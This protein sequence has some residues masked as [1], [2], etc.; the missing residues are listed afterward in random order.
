M[1]SHTVQKAVSATG[2]GFVAYADAEVD[3]GH[4]A[5]VKA[6]SVNGLEFRVYDP[7]NTNF[8]G[9]I[10]D[11]EFGEWTDE[12]NG[13]GLGRLT[14]RMSDRVV[15]KYRSLLADDNVIRVHFRNADRYAWRV[16]AGEDV[17][18][19][20]DEKNG[21][22][23]GL[24]GPGA[25]DVLEEAIVFPEYP[26]TGDP[27]REA[28]DRYFGYMSKSG[29]TSLHGSK[30]QY[31]LVT[32]PKVTS[33]SDWTAVEGGT[34]GATSVGSG[35]GLSGYNTLKWTYSSS[36]STGVFLRLD[37]GV[38][39]SVVP[40]SKMSARVS[41]KVSGD[42]PARLIAVFDTGEVADY[43]VTIP[44][45]EFYEMIFDDITVPAGAYFMR[46]GIKLDTN[47]HVLG[48]TVQMCWPLINT[49]NTSY[50]YFDGDS[51][52]NKFFIHDWAGTSNASVSS[53]I[54][55]M[56]TLS[57]NQPSWYLDSAWNHDFTAIRKSDIKKGT[58]KNAPEGWADPTAYVLWPTSP[59]LPSSPG[60]VYW[61][62]EFM[63]PKDGAV[64]LQ[65]AADNRLRVWIDGVEAITQG[66]NG[67]ATDITGSWD[68]ILKRGRHLIAAET[69]NF[70]SFNPGE[71]Y[72]WFLCSLLYKVGN[73]PIG[74]I[75]HTDKTWFSFYKGDT[76]V[77][78]V[79]T[80]S[81]KKS[82]KTVTTEKKVKVKYTVR[83][84][85]Y[86]IKIGN[87]YGIP[88]RDIYNA[89][90]AKIDSKAASTGLPNN[91]PG[92]WIFPGQKLTIPGKY[93]TTSVTAKVPT[94]VK[95]TKRAWASGT[96]LTTKQP[97]WYPYQVLA[98]LV[99]EGKDRNV[100]SLNN[101]KLGFEF[102]FDSDGISWQAGFD[103]I[104][105]RAFR[106]GSSIYDVAQELVDGGMD[107]RMSPDF[108][109]N[110]YREMGAYR[111]VN[112]PPQD[113]FELM[114]RGGTTLSYKV[115]KR[116]DLKNYLLIDTDRGW[117][118]FSNLDSD[119]T[120]RAEVSASLGGVNAD[121]IT[122]AIGD[123]LVA[124]GQR[125]KTATTKFLV[126]DGRTPYVD[127]DLGDVVV[128]R[129]VFKRAFDVRIVSMSVKEAEG[130]ITCTVIASG[131]GL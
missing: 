130:A 25:L 26:I 69:T 30:P 21:L 11:R 118:E 52:N 16:K 96:A 23:A 83:R 112:T 78:Y 71:N 1:F 88:W 86:L 75:T 97:G 45:G 42:T 131:E 28:P 100:S 109:L 40:A 47:A 58:A 48:R 64:F 31:N 72:G 27:I 57:N 108:T 120:G 106:V 9:T 4:Q 67:D 128:A 94:T 117:R 7:S 49:G 2:L 70:K 56:S 74:A 95:T 33:A 110:A 8:L 53:R 92:W 55:K 114:D 122:Q 103:S 35:S 93:T 3:L 36:G 80:N 24:D 105:D 98:Q 39:V 41:V 50:D 12:L 76:N 19:S 115:S 66:F 10:Q 104:I 124:L 127:F 84:G 101:V 17:I 63:M 102:G 126:V 107:I 77:P 111:G 121:K 22:T 129:D 119:E 62:N 46:L 54:I 59:Q 89:N 73:S 85:D 6:S 32:K 20:S 113:R 61:R 38:G 29:S 60:T 87:K 90:K 79:D 65:A 68:G 44:S 37:G 13:K 18:I 123:E 91:G 43:Q 81:T 5:A 116:T 34:A 125:T 51:P 99:T 82:S 14:A 15:S